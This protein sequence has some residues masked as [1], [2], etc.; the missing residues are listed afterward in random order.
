MPAILKTRQFACLSGG[1][2]ALRDGFHVEWQ[3]RAQFG[4]QTVNPAR[5]RPGEST[6]A[7]SIA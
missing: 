1:R 7:R 6:A 3:R 2:A 5:G 4:A